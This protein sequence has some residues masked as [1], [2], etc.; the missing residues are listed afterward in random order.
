MVK[1]EYRTSMIAD[2]KDHTL[3]QTRAETL[4]KP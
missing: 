2:P 4:Q 1:G 3:A